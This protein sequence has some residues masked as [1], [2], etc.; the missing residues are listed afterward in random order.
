VMFT[1]STET[2]S[3]IARR[4]ASRDDAPVPLIAET[5][6]QNCMIVD[7]TAL[8]EQ[9]VDD[10]VSSGFQSAGQRCSALRVLFLQEDIADKVIEM[11]IGAM[12][13]LSVGDP[14]LLSSDI[15]PVIDAKALA[16]L[17]EHVA[18]LENS[19]RLLYQCEAPERGGHTFFAPRLYEISNLSLLQ[20]EV[21][22]P[23]VH[24]VR[25][26]ADELE[27]VVEQINS[28]GY[29]LTFGVHSRIERATHTLAMQI[30]AG[31]VYINRNTIGAVVG[32]QPFGGHGLSG[33]GPKAGGPNYL[34][35]LVATPPEE[36]LVAA[37]QE[38]PSTVATPV[39]ECLR[40]LSAGASAWAGQS[41]VQRL[42]V[43]RQYL[44]SCA[45]TA[46]DA[47]DLEQ[48]LSLAREQLLYTGQLLGQP[49]QLPGPTGESNRLLLEPRGIL[50]LSLDRSEHNSEYLMA[51][52]SALAAGNVVV[53]VAGH[54]LL[55]NWREVAQGLRQAGLPEAAFQVLHQDGLSEALAHPALAGV[56][57]HAQ[58]PYVQAI[59]R[60][61][62]AREGAIL[63]LITSVSPQMLLRQTLLEKTVSIDT[64]AA[65]GNAS[66]MT[67]SAA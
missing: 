25:Y 32:V 60:A 55:D 8:P 39:E 6:G 40:M 45:D 46:P 30:H 27:Q 47:P 9:V 34:C 64:T 17:E 20:R 12:Q 28:T 14:S 58:S 4:L 23:V 66:L 43:L 37:Q 24:V 26:K 65:G 29:G 49:L 51:L 16:R 63:P 62:A 44:A 52:V 61:V 11:V 48:T 50:L 38:I 10:V 22:G 15:G 7:S 19:G 59:A 5:G 57:V 3:W 21:F 1:G 53:G 35:R 41:L 54:A 33:T 18:F 31:N 36:Q 67:M 56:M 2:G 42:S 13:Q